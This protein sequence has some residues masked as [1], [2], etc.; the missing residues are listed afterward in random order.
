M[1]SSRVE[2][3]R[4]YMIGLI[5]SSKASCIP[6]AI[7]LYGKFEGLKVTGMV[8]DIDRCGA[9]IYTNED[10]TEWRWIPFRYIYEGAHN[11]TCLVYKYNCRGSEDEMVITRG[12]AKEDLSS[13]LNLYI[14]NLSNE[15]NNKKSG[16]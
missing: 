7:T 1:K 11:E 16:E 5:R 10:E 12:L 14:H 2:K 13:L 9:K 6:V 8:G 15:M 3:E 4:E